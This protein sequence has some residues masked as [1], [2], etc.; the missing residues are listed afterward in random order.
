MA[1]TKDDP[2]MRVARERADVIGELVMVDNG[3]L[4]FVP[5]DKREAHPDPMKCG[6]PNN[7]FYDDEY[8]ENGRR[9]S[10]HHWYCPDCEYLQV[11]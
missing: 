4:T 7:E 6:H 2:F 5:P 8:D 9:I 1:E 11:G 3:S 10:K